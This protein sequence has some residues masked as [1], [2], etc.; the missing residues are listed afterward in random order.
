MPCLVLANA[1]CALRQLPHVSIRRL[2]EAE[3][4]L[5]TS[6]T[7]RFVRVSRSHGTT[8]KLRLLYESRARRQ[9]PY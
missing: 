7:K 4:Q 1:I 8:I 5:L 6:W 9:V 3:G 2:Q